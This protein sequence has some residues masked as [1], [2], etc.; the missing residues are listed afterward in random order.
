M[1]RDHTLSVVLPGGLEKN[2][3]VPGSKPVMDLLVTLCA[4]YHLNPS[5]YTV[6][7]LSHNKNNISFK[8]NS[9]VGSL[10]AQKM[11][12]KP[13]VVE[14][15]VRRPYMPEATVRLLVNYNKSHKT[16]VRVNPR[17]PLHTLLPVV[18]DKCEFNLEATV[19]LRDLQS[20]EPLD[21]TK[22]LNDLGLR[23]VF[24]KEATADAPVELIPP[25]PLQ[26]FVDLPKKE[27][28]QKENVGFLSLFRRKKQKQEMDVAKSPPSSPGL[29]DQ[30][31]S[32]V[33]PLGVQSPNSP[34]VDG[35][36]K[37]RA[38][39]PPMGSAQSLPNH[40]GSFHL[41]GPQS[42]AESTLK[43]TKRKAPLP[44][45]ANA[46]QEPLPLAEVQD[47]FSGQE[48]LR[49]KVLQRRTHSS[50][51]SSSSSPSTSSPQPS[52][53]H[54]PSSSSV[55]L[56]ARL[57]EATAPRLPDDEDEA[58]SDARLALARI[59]T[60]SLS[61]GTSV[62]RLKCSAAFP[63][64][65]PDLPAQ[66][67]QD[68]GGLCAQFDSVLECHPSAEEEREEP[69]QRE[70]LTTFTVVPS[71]KRNSHQEEVEMALAGRQ[72]ISVANDPTDGAEAMTGK[73]EAENSEARNPEMDL[74][75]VRHSPDESQTDI[76][77]HG[78]P[79]IPDSYGP[80]SPSPPPAPDSP[81][82]QHSHLSGVDV[83][84]ETPEEEEE[85]EVEDKLLLSDC[86]DEEPAGDEE[87]NTEE[88]DQTGSSTNEKTVEEE[89]EDSFPPPPPPISFNEDM[90]SEVDRDSPTTS[91]S[92]SSSS[93]SP[94]STG[95]SD[96]AS[97]APQC[98]TF[99]KPREKPNAL[100]SRFAQAVALAVQ[101]SR[102][103]KQA[104]P[105]APRSTYQYG[106]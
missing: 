11:V 35:P 84:L 66:K 78:S 48:D 68:D 65:N 98:S 32:G 88:L 104:G 26:E 83:G 101:R 38:P 53:P 56:V 102:V 74:Q 105:Q 5:D 51:S 15:K 34:G 41:Q 23:E 46:H 3:T 103:Q 14:E 73:A 12:L 9:P 27:K 82:R 50:S 89:E 80:T 24:A 59:L 60:S 1:E 49:A 25:P 52:E 57:R 92:S 91:S 62:K 17:V 45:S 64:S 75:E 90:G 37:R 81:D 6:E 20:R 70:G 55:S 69:V 94:T 44:P 33:D 106:A 16:V 29:V 30:T 71:K 21:V 58:S 19:L 2:T 63:K 18:C 31:A 42:S 28:K 97:P 61:Q 54:S 67:C 85:A 36:K 77:L 10:E 39:L 8:P 86:S 99:T 100:A 96:L 7:F 47:C 76:P 43:R 93:Q 13:R 72:L 40:L 22:T 87:S 4:S 95:Q 79:G